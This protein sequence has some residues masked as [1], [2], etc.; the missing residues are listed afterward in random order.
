MLRTEQ[1]IKKTK[2]PVLRA[3]KFLQGVQ[4]ENKLT[5]DYKLCCGEKQ[6]RRRTEKRGRVAILCWRFKK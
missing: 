6:I 3:F 1:Q 4:L 2:I 5:R